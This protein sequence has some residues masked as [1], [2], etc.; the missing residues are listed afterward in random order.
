[1]PTQPQ[2][3]QITHHLY[4]IY[5]YLKKYSFKNKPYSDIIRQPL[6]EDT[7]RELDDLVQ[8]IKL[9]Y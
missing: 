2:D 9:N 3:T 5:Q 8:H 7:Q 6:D 1:M 4:H